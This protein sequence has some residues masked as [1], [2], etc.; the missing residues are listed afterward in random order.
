MPSITASR[1]LRFYGYS[2]VAADGEDLPFRSQWE[3]TLGGRRPRAL[4]AAHVNYFAAQFFLVPP[5]RPFDAA[6]PLSA[7]G[8]PAAVKSCTSRPPATPPGLAPWP[9]C[10]P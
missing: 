2:V 5:T 8:K 4:S 1:P 10:T 3:L 9:N 6:P 7:G